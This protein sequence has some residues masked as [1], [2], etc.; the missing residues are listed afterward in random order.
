MNLDIKE[1]IKEFL[2]SEYSAEEIE[3]M[4]AG[5]K[6]EADNSR[7]TITYDNGVVDKCKYACKVYLVQ[8][9]SYVPPN[10]F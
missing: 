1:M 4:L 6:I 9:S 7:V 2:S 5:A 3:G 8:E 10:N